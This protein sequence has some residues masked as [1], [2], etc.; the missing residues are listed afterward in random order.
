MDYRVAFSEFED[1]RSIGL[2]IVIDSIA[3]AV[4]AVYEVEF[5]P[6]EY[7]I[8][9]VVVAIDYALN[10]ALLAHRQIQ[11]GIE[12]RD[13]GLFSYVS[14]EETGPLAVIV[15]G[16][17]EFWQGNMEEGKRGDRR[18][19]VCFF[20]IIAGL[21]IPINLTGTDIAPAF[22][23]KQIFAVAAVENIKDSLNAVFT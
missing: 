21:A 7:A 10:I 5:L 8:I 12:P 11:S 2:K 16:N 15:K 3:S 17:Q 1:S 22:H 6:K 19:A 18:A 20:E 23:F 9:I 4:A 13:C 14:T